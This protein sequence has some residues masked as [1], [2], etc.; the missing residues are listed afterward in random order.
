MCGWSLCFPCGAGHPCYQ[1]QRIFEQEGLQR[2]R[3]TDEER[4]PEPKAQRQG[5]KGTEMEGT[6][7]SAERRGGPSDGRALPDASCLLRRLLCS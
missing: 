3:F 7:A 6:E 5:L 4:C 2:A 1:T